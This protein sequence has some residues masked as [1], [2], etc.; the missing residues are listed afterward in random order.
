MKTLNT[1][2]TMTPEAFMAALA[3]L[4]WKQSDFCRKKTKLFYDSFYIIHRKQP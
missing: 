3:A 1:E 4:G 2:M